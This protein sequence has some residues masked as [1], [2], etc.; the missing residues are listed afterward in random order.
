MI[1]T[2]KSSESYVLNMSQNRELERNK[3]KIMQWLTEDGYKLQE[4]P[5]PNVQFHLVA[6]HR[7]GIKLDI[8]QAANMKDKLVIHG[9]VKLQDDRKQKLVAMD[10][11][12]Q[13]N[14]F[15]D[16]R[17]VMLNNNIEF[18]NLVN[19]SDLYGIQTLVYYDGLNK[20]VFMEKFHRL[21][22]M[23]FY[24]LMK[25]DKL[26]GQPEPSPDLRYIG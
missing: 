7:A 9:A 14:L 5:D 12:K 25:F 3:A 10:L 24:M 26:F 13:L 21:Q 17:F 16:L 23:M 15:W 22:N 19:T 1:D 11:E 20:N 18:E 2:Y 6:E 4:M 8:V